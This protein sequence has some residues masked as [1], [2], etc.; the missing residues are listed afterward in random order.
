MAATA[1]AQSTNGTY[2]VMHEVVSSAG[3]QIGG[4]NP[5]SAQTI[6]G[7]PIGG[8]ATNGVFTLVGGL[9]TLRGGDGAPV[10]MAIGVVGT[11]DDPAATI[12]VNGIPATI[13]GTTFTASGIQLI[14]GANTITVVATDA[15]GNQATSSIIVH[16]DLAP[17]DKTYRFEVLVTGPIDDPTAS[18]TVNSVA[19]AVSAGAFAASVPVTSGYNTLTATA[20]DPADNQTS[21]SIEIFVPPPTEPPPMPTVGT[22]GNPLP[23][24][25][26]AAT[27]TIGGTK[28]PGTSIWING[29]EVYPADNANTW[30]ATLT[31]NEGDNELIIVAKDVTGAA[32]AEVRRNVIVDNLPPVVTFDPLAK[33]NFNPVPLSGSTDDSLTTVTI[34]GVPAARA[35]SAFNVNVPLAM[36]AN[37]LQLIA[38]SPNGYVTQQA[39]HITLGTIPTLLSIAPADGE[40]LTAGSPITIQAT[41]LDQE[42]D[43]MEYQVTIDGTPFADWSSNASPLWTPDLTQAGLR[44]LTV[45]VR[46]AYGGAAKQ[47]LEVYVIRPPVDHP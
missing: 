28:T 37:T 33:T 32:S 42:G 41:A 17:Q 22:I 26:T 7:L 45:S 10:T 14:A 24:V 5:M 35:G 36:G 43:P 39:Y 19:A 3:G 47:D 13:T 6:L 44:T 23:Q 16:V 34:N 46:D 30:S 29:Q 21:A 40:T 2:T 31:L 8:A 11:T 1:S 12:T 25:T 18:V 15:L 38:T 27:I 9:G 4:G 20:T